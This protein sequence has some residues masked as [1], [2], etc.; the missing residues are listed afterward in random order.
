VPLPARHVSHQERASR[1]FAEASLAQAWG[2]CVLDQN[3]QSSA[4]SGRTSAP[5]TDKSA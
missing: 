3:A 4:L 2:T 1:L 5:A